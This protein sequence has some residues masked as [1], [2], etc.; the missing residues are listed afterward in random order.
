M[1]RAAYPTLQH[2]AKLAL[3]SGQM[4]GAT[5]V[6][7]AILAREWMRH[8]DAGRRGRDHL[9][10]AFGRALVR[11]ATELGATFI[12]LGQIASTRGDL[13]A[14]PLR[15]ELATLQDRVPPYPFQEV[16]RTIESE[17]GLPLEAIYQQFEPSP[18]AAA[19]VAQVHR[20]VLRGSDQWVAVKVRRPDIVEKVARDRSILLLLSRVLERVLP[21]LRLVSLEGA[22]RSFCDAVEQQ[23]HLSNEAQH[24]RR[25][26]Q[27]FADE[28]EVRF[29]RLFPAACSD[30]VLTMEFIEGVHESGLEAAGIDLHRVV[31]AGMRVVCRMIFLHGFVHADL[32]PGN[33]RFLA[34]GQ[35]VLLDLGLVGRLEDADR[36]MTARLLFA[37]ATGDGPTVA[38]LFYD[39]APSRATPDYPA[40]ERE[41]VEL[42]E[43]VRK[44]GLANLQVTLEIGRIFDI[45]RRHRI[46][47]RSHMTMVNLALMT[48][49]GL[50]R[51]L[52]PELSLSDEALPYLAEALGVESPQHAA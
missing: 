27:N 14:E 13:L 19:S 46:Q 15:R 11:L 45:L 20:A 44:R 35:I 43:S 36:V 37:L 5:A 24:N 12:K 7:L 34:P 32:H 6:A 47:A 33:L 49:E 21:S 22:V 42:V 16:R 25:F 29:P 52:A 31:S 2:V 3:R 30:A 1:P 17:L 51:R 40:Y 18:V 48:A 9:L 39:N 4:V 8:P 50:G 23:I 28:T 10:Q 38:R 26:A 41:M